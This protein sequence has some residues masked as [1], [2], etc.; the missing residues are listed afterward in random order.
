[1][2]SPAHFKV[3]CPD[4]SNYIQMYFFKK[5]F[6][7]SPAR[8]LCYWAA[9]SSLLLIYLRTSPYSLIKRH[10]DKSHQQKP[11]A[12]LQSCRAITLSRTIIFSTHHKSSDIPS[13]Y[14]IDSYNLR[15]SNSPKS[16]VTRSK[17]CSNTFK[18]TTC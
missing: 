14:V 8:T 3:S 1:M 10:F 4:G 11:F 16:Q 13:I 12:L 6:A 9:H 2:Y 18:K 5:T 15:V 7:T 17:H